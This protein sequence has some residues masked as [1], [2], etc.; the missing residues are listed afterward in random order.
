MLKIKIVEARIHNLP[1]LRRMLARAVLEHFAYFPTEVQ[2]RVISDH[3]LPRLLLASIDRRRILL[4]AHAGGRLIGYCLGA[5]PKE[6]AAQI[7]WLFVEPDQRGHNTGLS[8]LSRMLKMLE[9][10]GARQ[11]AIATHDHRRYYERQGFKFEGTRRI[12]GV[13][14]DI[15]TFRITA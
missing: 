1:A 13:D 3:S 14:M 2:R 9:K 4:T 12:D 11:V 10:R 8:L 5:A 15:L 6:G 7:Y